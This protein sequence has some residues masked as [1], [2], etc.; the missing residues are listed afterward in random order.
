MNVSNLVRV[1]W[2]KILAPS[3]GRANKK[4]TLEWVNLFERMSNINCISTFSTTSIFVMDMK[5]KYY[6]FALNTFR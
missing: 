2:R 1:E 4:P 6:Y 5:R 3:A